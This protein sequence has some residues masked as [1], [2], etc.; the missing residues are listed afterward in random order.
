MLP[1]LALALPHDD[2]AMSL[3]EYGPI[4]G[5]VG[6]TYDFLASMST[7]HLILFLLVN[8]PI[9]SIVGNA[10]YQLVRI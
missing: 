10:I 8:I 1:Q 4:A 7:A 3:S 5:F 9:L 2:D 6:H